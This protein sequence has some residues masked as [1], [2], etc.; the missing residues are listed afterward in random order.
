MW[1]NTKFFDPHQRHAALLSKGMLTKMPRRSGFV[2]AECAALSQSFF[3][4]CG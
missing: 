2:L 3:S 1:I 4:A